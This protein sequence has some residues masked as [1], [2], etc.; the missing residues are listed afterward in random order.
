[1]RRYLGRR[2]ITAIVCV[3]MVLVA[4]FAVIHLAPGNP[5]R[6]LV[7]TETPTQ[8]QI[9][10]LNARFGLDRPIYE[11]FFRYVAGLFRGDLG[12]SFFT[13]ESVS[14]LITSRLGYTALLTMS[15]LIMAVIIG[16]LM[17]IVCSRRVGGKLDTFM[18]AI[19]SLLESFPSFWLGLMMMLVFAAWLGWLPFSGIVDIRAGHTGF[20][21]VLDIGRHLILPAST[22]TLINI[23]Y[24][25]RIARSSM[26]QTLGEDFI[27][28]L[29]AA[30][31]PEERIFGKYVFRNAVLPS[32]TAVSI[33][34]AYVVTGSALVEM[35]FSWPGMGS[36][37]MTSIGRRDYP[38]LMG[39]YLM[40]SVSV[41]VVM[42]LVDIL[43][44][45]LDPRV[46]HATKG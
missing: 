19:S 5:A 39:I 8:A 29:R 20:A 24:F 45:F 15:G 33:S 41:A 28:T 3:A 13:G 31:M 23:P 21:R 7:G 34:M 36:Y 40:L 12:V 14:W 16:T 43:Y 18:T 37:M 35:V 9:D 11:Q 26:I 10:M 2:T 46:S 1:M 38:V 42:I 44:A 22:L 32:V 6:V 27:V 30:G 4:N 17:G 25:F